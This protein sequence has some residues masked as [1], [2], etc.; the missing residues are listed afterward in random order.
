MSFVE[1]VMPAG[2]DGTY[3]AAVGFFSATEQDWEKA[4]LAKVA[5]LKK[6][7]PDSP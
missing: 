7:S 2:F 6:A 3:Q 5:E 1:K 4:T